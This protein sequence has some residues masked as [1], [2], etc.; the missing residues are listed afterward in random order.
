MKK[1]CRIICLALA[2][3]LIAACFSIM[4]LGADEAPEGLWTDYAA[5]AFDGGSGTKDDPYK[6]ATAEQLAL[7][8][9]DVNSGVGDKTHTKEYFIL[10]ADID[11]SAH[12]W[13]PLGYETYGGGSTHPFDGF[14]DG[15]GKKITGLYVDERGKNKSAGLFGCVVIKG[16]DP[17]IQN[18]TVDGTVF[19]GDSTDHDNENYGAGILIGTITV[20]GGSSVEYGVIKD[21]KVSG[22]VSS[23]MCAGGLVGDAN[24]THFENCTADVKVEGH[25]ISGGFVGQTFISQFTDCVAKGNVTSKGWSTGGFA[26][27]L[28]CE[29]TVTHCAAYGDVEA[30]NWN[31]GGFV[32]YA[33]ED[34][35]I[36]NSIAMGNVTS[37]VSG[38]APR[39]GGFAGTFDG[40]NASCAIEK[41]SA[42]GKVTTAEGQVGYGMVAYITGDFKA[43]DCS[44]NSEKN[45]SLDAT[46]AGALEG[47]EAK[48][49]AG[50]LAD[51]CANYDGGHDM[52]DIAEV[53]A[54]C[55]ANGSTAGK[56]CKKC[57]Y[58]EGIT[59]IEAKG[60]TYSDV[61]SSDAT[62][63]WHECSACQARADQADHV[64]D[65]DCDTDC[66]VCGKTRTITHKTVL[67][68]K[69]DPTCEKAGST[70]HYKCSCCGK[71]F[72]DVAATK[73]ITDPEKLVLAA[74]GHTR[75]GD[76]KTSE[77]YHWHE[78]TVCGERIDT[79]FHRAGED[80]TETTSQNCAVC[81]YV[82]KE[83]L[84]HKHSFDQKNTDSKH[85]KSAATC[86]A[87]AVYYYSCACGENGTE[88]FESGDKLA[89][90][91]KTEW[92]SDASKHWH[93]CSLCGDKKDESNHSFEWKTDKEAAVGVAG[94][95]HE[96]CTVCGFKKEAVAIDPIAP[97]TT[98]TTTS[99]TTTDG[100]KEGGCKSVIGTGVIVATIGLAAASFIVIRKKENK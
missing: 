99:A 3:C 95:K 57:G 30:N 71:L 25:C 94:S 98:T 50:V 60:H 10:T 58:T 69:V 82:I 28:Y 7:L 42:N 88:T 54:T 72:Y 32:G 73:E 97:A 16:N 2:I 52:E 74:T 40:N 15:N 85:L 96:E 6:I 27:I 12:V 78:C 93:E 81:G 84:G 59:V 44:F 55:T 80:A 39:A 48:N 92:S 29:T 46:A 26:G 13:T 83:A 100:G 33:E 4:A 90:S 43:T 70:A 75:G 31:L 1:N 87:S 14:F 11:L 17:V 23:A 41:C 20:S 19:A 86:K 18:L 51:I 47:A 5:D 9:K 38:F 49:T 68:E 21:C 62:S 53:K 34:V 64:Y 35:T 37:N 22:T 76:W 63:H 89:H 8:A 91:F 66:N 36:K 79:A 56:K 67:I 77:I 61:W 24:Y 45:P 65:N